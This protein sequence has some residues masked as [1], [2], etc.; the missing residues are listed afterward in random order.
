MTADMFVG[1]VPNAPGQ[2]FIPHS[3]CASPSLRL[4]WSVGWG[5]RCGQA[6]HGQP[7]DLTGVPDGSYVLRGTVDPEHVLTERNPDNNVVDT[8]LQITGNRVTVL[9][10]TRP[11]VIPPVITLTGPAGGSHVSGTVTLH[12]ST[13][14]TAPAAVTSVQFLLDGWPLGPPRTSAPYTYAWRAGGTTRGTHQLSAQVTDSRG[15]MGTAPVE[16]VTVASSVPPDQRRVPPKQA[17]GHAAPGAG[18]A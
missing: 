8:R 17:R 5:D 16:T 1:G 7:I 12:A 18:P 10:Q 14:A 6:G 13:S 15:N 2:T 4:G 3:N 11:T 9:S